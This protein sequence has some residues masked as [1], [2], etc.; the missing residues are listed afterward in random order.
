MYKSLII[1]AMPT[2]AIFSFENRLTLGGPS[3]GT[4]FIR[5]HCSIKIMDWSQGYV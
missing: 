3:I 5:L 2:D 4:D 1:Q